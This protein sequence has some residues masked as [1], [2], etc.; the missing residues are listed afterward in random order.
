MKRKKKRLI[1]V[2]DMLNG[3]CKEGALA[4]PQ[5]M[6]TIVPNI[7]KL[8]DAERQRRA[9]GSTIVF[10]GDY[11]EKDDVEF[12]LFPPHCIAGTDEAEIIREMGFNELKETRLHKSKYSPFIPLFRYSS[13]V[14]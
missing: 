2:V 1:V 12:N 11:H 14:L 8:L 10:I 3:F 4:S 9:E 6:Q 7:Q 5:F 13:A